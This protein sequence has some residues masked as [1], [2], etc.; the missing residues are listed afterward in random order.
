M[1]NG[2]S[3]KYYYLRTILAP[4]TAFRELDGDENRLRYSFWSVTIIAIVYTFVYIFL[5]VGGGQPF[6]PWLNIPI[7][8]YYKYNV[9]FCA[10]SMFLG[11]VLAAGVVHLISSM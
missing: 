8:V 4:S 11:W 9:F 7:E 5:I 1:R 2:R 6:K 10:P 3:F